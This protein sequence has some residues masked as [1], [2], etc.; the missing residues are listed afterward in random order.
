MHYLQKA[1]K[2]NANH[3]LSDSSRFTGT[4]YGWGAG[5]GGGQDPVQ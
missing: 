3:T 1:F 4:S 5:E 2:S